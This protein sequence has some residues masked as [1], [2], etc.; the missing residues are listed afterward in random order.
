MARLQQLETLLELEQNLDCV[1]VIDTTGSMDDYIVAVKE[2]VKQLMEKI[3]KETNVS[4]VKFAVVAYRDH[5]QDGNSYG[6]VVK[7]KPLSEWNV[8]E[9]FVANL[10]A[11]GGG[12]TP[13]ATLDGL[14]EAVHAV[15]W[16]EVS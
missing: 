8:I 16:R 14:N 3:K 4:S 7:T 12:D 9:S 1:F 2:A 13:E 11:D 6:Y 5:P 15:E 10:K